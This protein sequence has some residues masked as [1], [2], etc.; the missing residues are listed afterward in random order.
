MIF[1]P[2]MRLYWGDSSLVECE[3]R[4]MEAA[5]ASNEDYSYFHLLSGVDL[6]IKKTEE[7]HKFFDE[8]PNKQFIVLRNPYSGIMGMDRYYFFFPL[9][10]YNK[11]VA[12]GLDIVSE[13]I[14][15]AWKVNR[16]KNANYKI[17]KSQK[18]FSITKECAEYVITQKP[19]IKQFTRYTSCSDEM[20]LGTVLINSPFWEQVYEPFRSS[21][22]HVRLIDRERSEKASPHTWLM[23]DWEMIENSPYFWARK[24]D[25]TRDAEI[26]EKVF[27][28]WK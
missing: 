27:E 21:G 15:N 19:F 16:L 8:H 11:Y 1:I 13:K 3:L 14:Q 28:T 22:G 23:E 24:F 5:L 2:R 9:R 17:C 12:K 18:W 20:F 7:V 6:Q 4:L 26:I 10:S 25:E